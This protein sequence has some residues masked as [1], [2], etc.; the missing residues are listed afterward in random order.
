MDIYYLKNAKLE[1]KH[2]KYNRLV[3]LRGDL[4]EDDS[5]AYE[6]FTE[7]GS[8]AAQV[9]ALEVVDI[10]SRLPFCDGQAA[11][12]VF[13]HT[14]ENEGCSQIMEKFKIRM[15]RYLDNDTNGLNHG[16]VS[17]TQL[18]LLSAICTVIFWQDYYGKA[19]WEHLF[20]YGCEKVSY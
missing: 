14:K 15:S 20:Q 12:A 17:K 13:A 4:A 8:S 3:L 9:T 5:G 7:E 19:I 1:A 18:F 11:D 2:Q 6:V 10:I 16:E